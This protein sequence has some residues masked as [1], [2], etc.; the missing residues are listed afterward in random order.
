MLRTSLKT[1]FSCH[2]QQFLFL[3]FV[4]H[5]AQ[6]LFQCINILFSSIYN[7]LVH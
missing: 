2:G 6:F 3:L 5:F 1:T 7:A 4:S